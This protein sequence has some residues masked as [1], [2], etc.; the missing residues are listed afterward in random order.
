M[1]QFLFQET[2]EAARTIMQHRQGSRDARMLLAASIVIV[3]DGESD[4]VVDDDVNGQLTGVR[5]LQLHVDDVAV[6]LDNVSPMP[7]PI[8]CLFEL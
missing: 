1:V 5:I 4:V 7:S 3:V 6:R 2:W 8:L